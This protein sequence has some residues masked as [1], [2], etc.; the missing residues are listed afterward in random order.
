MNVTQRYRFI[1]K[2]LVFAASLL[3][4]AWLIC[5]AMQWLGASLGADPVKKLEHECGKTAL[6]FLLLTLAVSPVRSLAGL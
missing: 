4:L 2:P 3:P 1:Y 6:N 5:G